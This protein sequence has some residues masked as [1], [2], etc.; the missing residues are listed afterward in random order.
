MKSGNKR[1]VFAIRGNN[2]KAYWLALLMMLGAAGHTAV[3]EA[4]PITYQ[5]IVQ[6][7]NGGLGDVA[8]NNVTAIFTFQGDTDNIYNYSVP[9][10]DGYVNSIGTAS[11]SILESTG[12]FL[13][14]ATFAPDTVYVSVD[15]TNAGIG[16][17]TYT[18]SGGFDPVYPY[19]MFA[20]SDPA[21]SAYD[22][23]TNYTLNYSAISCSGFETGTCDNYA[24]NIVPLGTNRGD[25]YVFAEGMKGAYFSAFTTGSPVSAVPEPAA[26]A[27]LP[28]SLVMLGLFRRDSGKRR[29]S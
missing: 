12:A 4:V 8:L 28:L 25:F 26:L 23:S 29:A 15:N 17:G 6:N 20:F 5:Q 27:L 9:G 14:E 11:V 22:L 2:F 7:I 24:P 16:F 3:A 10:A 21:I 19:A 18:G 1:Q 13:Y